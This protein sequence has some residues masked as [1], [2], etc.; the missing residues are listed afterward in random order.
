[1]QFPHD[2]FGD[3]YG[4]ERELGHGATAT[5]YLA[6]DLKFEDKLVAI[7]VL[8]EHFALPVPRERFLREIQTTAK[9]NHPHIV[10][11]IEDGHTWVT[12]FGI[13]RAMAATDSQT[14]TSTGVTIGTPAYMSPEQAMGRGDL[15]ARSDIYSLGCV[16]YEM[17]A[18]KMPFDGPDVQV[19][20]NKHLVEPLPPIRDF[21]PDVPARIEQL[22]D[23]AL[24]KKRED[25]YSSATDFADALSLE[26]AGPVTPTRTQPV[27]GERRKPV[28]WKSRTAVAAV[29]TL[30]LGILVVAAWAL[31]RPT[32][33]ADRFLVVP[34]W[35]YG[36][37]VSPSMNAGRLLQDQLNQWKGITVMT[38]PDSA[39]ARRPRA[40]ARRGKAAWYIR[41]DVSRVGDSLKVRAQLYGDRKSTRLNSS[42]ITIS[43]AV[44]CLKK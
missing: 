28:R 10:T 11:M 1:M 7:K 18:G 26:G 15:D 22:L 37:G 38:T 8:S 39:A 35:E 17:L 13:A 24:A 12:D 25:R 42:H 31:T 5:V 40:A 23:I 34:V 33:K 14:V 27:P 29:A 43:Y 6:R 36:E 20:L 2:D 30:M 19:I 4:I 32:L 16:L 21:R 9:L 41:G 3:R 44:F